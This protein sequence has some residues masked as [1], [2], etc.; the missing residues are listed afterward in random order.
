MIVVSIK[1]ADDFTKENLEELVMIVV[2]FLISCYTCVVQTNNR[3]QCVS[4][5]LALTA[6][7]GIMEWIRHI[8]MVYSNTEVDVNGCSLA[9]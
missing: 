1:I 2:T 9:Y 6:S 5:A 3:M 7:L 8:F 4:G